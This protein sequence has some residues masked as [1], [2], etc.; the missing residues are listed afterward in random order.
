MQ[1]AWLLFD[2]KAIRNAAG[3]PNGRTPLNL[4]VVTELEQLP[5]PKNDLYELLRE[6][7]GLHGRRRKR[8][9]VNIAARRVAEF[10]DDFTPLRTLPAFKALEAEVETIVKTQNYSFIASQPTQSAK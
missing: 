4:P 1:E 6:A 2:E 9:A 7:S 10:I 8:F 5:D 3:N